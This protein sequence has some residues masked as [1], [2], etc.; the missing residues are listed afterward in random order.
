MRMVRGFLLVASLIYP[1][2]AE[3]IA[4]PHPAPAAAFY[5][6][7][8]VMGAVE[9]AIV[10]V[11]RKKTEPLQD[12]TLADKTSLVRWRA[13]HIIVY[14]LALSVVLYGLV[15]RVAGATLSQAVPFY[16]AGI[17]MLLLFSPKASDRVNTAS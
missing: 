17:A 1:F 11:I 4:K 6:A 9:I 13:A 16:T 7:I 8:L 12:A 3:K 2:I 10:V 5:Y 14:A 15:V